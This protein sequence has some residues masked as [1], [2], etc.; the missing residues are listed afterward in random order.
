MEHNKNN[1]NNVAAM[2][3]RC[4]FPHFSGAAEGK[5]LCLSCRHV[6]ACVFLEIGYMLKF[7]S[8][9]KD[10]NTSARN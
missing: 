5:R 10:F 7:F 3:M 2:N 8:T 4:S 6:A 9:P 1:K